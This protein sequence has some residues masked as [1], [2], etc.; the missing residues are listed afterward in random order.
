[1]KNAVFE[2]KTAPTTFSSASSAPPPVCGATE[3]VDFIDRVAFFE[4]CVFRKKR[5]VTFLNFG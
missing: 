4:R 5:S 3:N 1:M 2:G